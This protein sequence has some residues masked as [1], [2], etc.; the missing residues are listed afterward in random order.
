MRDMAPFAIVVVAIY[1][2]TVLVAFLK[3][4]SGRK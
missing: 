3:P 1:K 4:S 2:E